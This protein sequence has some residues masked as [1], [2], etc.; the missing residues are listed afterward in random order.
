[1][2]ADISHYVVI[3]GLSALGIRSIFCHVDSLNISVRCNRGLRNFAY[4]GETGKAGSIGGTITGFINAAMFPTRVAADFSSYG[5][6]AHLANLT[7]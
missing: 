7:A 6:D 5:I 2:E 4:H 3:V 1:M